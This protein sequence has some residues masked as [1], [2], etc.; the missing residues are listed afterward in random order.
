MKIRKVSDVI[1]PY[2][3]R[4][5]KRD[6]IRYGITKQDGIN[7]ISTNL[8]SRQFKVC[9]EDAFCEKERDSICS[10]VPVY[11]NRTLHDGKKLRRLR[12]LYDCNAFRV[13]SK[14]REA[15]RKSIGL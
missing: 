10:N 3:I 12:K 7:L 8:S 6:G 13:L 15:Y 14:D 11:S 4:V 1:S 2:L 9:M 5:L